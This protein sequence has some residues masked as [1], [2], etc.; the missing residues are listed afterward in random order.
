LFNFLVNHKVFSGV[1]L[2]I[3]FVFVVTMHLEF[4]NF[5]AK[6][7]D[8]PL[9]RDKYN[10][11]VLI[12][13]SCLCL[14]FT[15]WFF[16]GIKRL[17]KK[18]RVVTSTYLIFTLGL[19]VAS[20][21]IIMVVNVELIHVLQYAIFAILLFTIIQKYYDTLFWTTFFGAV[22]ELYQYVFLAPEKTDYFD[23]N[24][25]I[26]NM[27]GAV[28]GLLLLRAHAK[29]EVMSDK[30]WF[31]SSWFIGMVAI[32]FVI[33]SLWLFGELTFYPSDKPVVFQFI[34]DFTPGFWRE[35]PPK[36]LFH[37]IQ[38][39]EGLVI[40]IILFFIY[41]KLPLSHPSNNNVIVS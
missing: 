24:D 2:A 41:K 14:G 15:L 1:L 9:G 27:T 34:R 39:F 37:V 32:F 20:I 6:T 23:I 31:K 25:V 12:L 13:A 17:N 18:E 38:P 10:I 29:Y 4:G 8:V 30:V 21:N 5:I 7:L 40:L 16:K 33:T 26:I 11:V 22:D 19:I 36:V 35:I 3:Y 28:M